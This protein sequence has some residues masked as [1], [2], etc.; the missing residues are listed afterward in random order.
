MSPGNRL[1]FE[2]MGAGLLLGAVL[3][4]APLPVSAQIVF[5]GNILWGNNDGTLAGQF[6]GTAGAGV[7]ACPG[8]T[9]LQIGTVDYI[10][11]SLVDPLLSG[12]LD[13]DHPN[14]RPAGGS[15]A[16]AG[17]GGHGKTVNVPAD[18]FF[19]PVCYVG[20]L[21]PEGTTDWTQGWTY[22]DSTGAGRQD[23]HLPGMPDPRP[24]AILQGNFYVNRTLAADSNYVLRGTVRVKDQAKLTIPAGTVIFGERSTLGTL[25]VERGGRIDAQGTAGAPIIFTSD[26]APG[27]QTRG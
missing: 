25:V 11:N 1:G 6:T 16:Y 27:T 10:E 15:P 17:N 22:Y 13:I 2:T 18:G 14:W 21:G 20:A 19:E 26:D 5:D 4:G 7:A 9:A 23:L 3:L 8:K 12:A 24:T